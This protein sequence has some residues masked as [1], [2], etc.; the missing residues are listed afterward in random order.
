MQGYEADL[1]EFAL[2]MREILFLFICNAGGF[3]QVNRFIQLPA[4]GKEFDLEKK[5]A[6]RF[7]EIFRK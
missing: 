1:E 5:R 4:A 3:Q 6:F 2:V 7:C